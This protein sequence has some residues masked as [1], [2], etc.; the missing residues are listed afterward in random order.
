ML[1]ERTETG[2]SVGTAVV[3]TMHAG[4]LV[5]DEVVD[6]MVEE[7]LAEPDCAAGFILD[8]HPGPWRGGVSDRVDGPVPT[9]CIS[10]C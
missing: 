1:R 6:R 3:A 2:S 10:C 5:A 7:R 8:G 9:Q 4:S